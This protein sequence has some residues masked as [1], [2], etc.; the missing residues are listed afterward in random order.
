MSEKPETDDFDDQDVDDLSADNQ[1]QDLERANKDL[2]L[3]RKRG[4]KIVG[5]PAWRR[6]EELQEKKRIQA[7]ISDF[8]D[9]DIGLD[10]KPSRGKSGD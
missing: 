10:D 6:L 2:E 9:Y 5:D 3:S 1:D 4:T 8:E 7:L